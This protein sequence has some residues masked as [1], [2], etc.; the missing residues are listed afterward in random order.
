MP[1]LWSIYSEAVCCK[2]MLKYT[3]S[4][5]PNYVY[6]MHV[7]AKHKKGN[8]L[9]KSGGWNINS[10]MN[11]TFSNIWSPVIIGNNCSVA[12]FDTCSI[13]V[14][15]RRLNIDYLHTSTAWKIHVWNHYGHDEIS[16]H[17]NVSI[18]INLSVWS[19]RHKPIFSYWQAWSS[20]LQWEVP[21]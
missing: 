3:V 17:Y 15:N 13:R 4:I 1:V 20:W 9:I 8:N 7:H 19:E 18:D 10:I 5:L 16:H 2:K 12:M 6:C 21:L 14:F 11:N